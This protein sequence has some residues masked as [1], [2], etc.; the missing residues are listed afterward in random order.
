MVAGK[1]L[2]QSREGQQVYWWITGMLRPQIRFVPPFHHCPDNRKNRTQHFYET[3]TAALALP[4]SVSKMSVDSYCY[5]LPAAQ[6]KNVCSEGV[7]EKGIPMCHVGRQWW[8]TALCRVITWPWITRCLQRAARHPCVMRRTDK[9]ALSG[10]KPAC[11]SHMKNYVKHSWS[12]ES[13]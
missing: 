13:E 1:K 6:L 10:P 8:F 7:H 2:Q 12:C 9:K 5:P 4:C 3:Q 11:L